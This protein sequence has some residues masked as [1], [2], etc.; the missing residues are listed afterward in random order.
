MT[1]QW[2]E[3]AYRLKKCIEGMAR[4]AGD[5]YFA[6]TSDANNPEVTQCID[7][8]GVHSCELCGSPKAGT[9]RCVVRIH[10]LEE[11]LYYSVCVDCE[12]V[13]EYGQLDDMSMLEIEDDQDRR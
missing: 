1:D 7:E 10:P 3:P 5:G 2:H 11:N 4:E 13:V 6:N 12:H 9:R 8:F